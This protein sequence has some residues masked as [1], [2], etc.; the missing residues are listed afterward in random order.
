MV[1]SIG[2]Y[3]PHNKYSIFRDRV[4]VLLFNRGEFVFCR[5][6][7]ADFAGRFLQA[8]KEAFYLYRKKDDKELL[9]AFS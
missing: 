3:F 1:F 5:A 7:F 6:F 8:L 2:G 9:K 4:Q